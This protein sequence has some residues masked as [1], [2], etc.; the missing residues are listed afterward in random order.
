MR[1]FI[2]TLCQISYFID[3]NEDITSRFNEQSSQLDFSTT[4][5]FVCCS[6]ISLFF[7]HFLPSLLFLGIVQAC[8]LL[9]DFRFSATRSSGVG[10]LA[11]ANV[12]QLKI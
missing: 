11:V 4:I 10:C 9:V 1:I 6:P 12:R 7:D 3:D 8:P 5:F 2:P